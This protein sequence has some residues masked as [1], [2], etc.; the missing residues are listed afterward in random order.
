MKAVHR[1]KTTGGSSDQQ[2][3]GSGTA[4]DQTSGLAFGVQTVEKVYGDETFEV[5]VLGTEETK[6]ITYSSS[7]E[8]VA[9]VTKRGKVSIQGVGTTVITAAVMNGKKA[10]GEKSFLYAECRQE[11]VGLGYK[12]AVRDRPGRPDYGQECDALRRDQA[13]RNPAK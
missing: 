13:G 8:T 11:T 7:D 2:V 5:V 3:E 9:T 1:I 6:N 10:T 12:R 4:G